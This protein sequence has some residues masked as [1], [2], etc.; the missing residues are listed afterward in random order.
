MHSSV[1][2]RCP[3]ELICVMPADLSQEPRCFLVESTV[4][5]VTAVR[6]WTADPTKIEILLEVKQSTPLNEKSVAKLGW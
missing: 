1:A 3:I 6:P 4:G 2:R 5:K